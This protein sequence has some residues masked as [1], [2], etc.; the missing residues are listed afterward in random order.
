M[1]LLRVFLQIPVSS[2]VGEMAPRPPQSR[3]PHPAAVVLGAGAP[4][5]LRF[6]AEDGAAL[7][8]P[9]PVVRAV[10]LPVLAEFGGEGLREEEQLDVVTT[11][12][13]VF[14]Y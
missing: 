8:L 6:V 5:L 12:G 4:L 14:L 1:L 11:G 7:V 9:L 10:S 2:W 3:P 13:E